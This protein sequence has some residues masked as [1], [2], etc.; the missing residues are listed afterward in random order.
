[1]RSRLAAP[2][3]AWIV[4]ALLI[5]VSATWL[6]AGQL[7]WGDDEDEP[8]AAADE[9][10][11]PATTP[12]PDWRAD[13]YAKIDQ[14]RGGLS[15]DYFKHVLGTPIFVTASD[16]G[17]YTQYLFRRRDYWVQA[18]GNPAGAVAL[19][20]VTSCDE[21]FRPVFHRFPA[22]SAEFTVTLNETM[23]AELGPPSDLHYFIG[24]TANTYFYDEYY[25]ANPGD[26]KTVWFGIND[27]CPGGEHT[28]P[29]D[30][31][32]AAVFIGREGDLVPDDPAVDEWSRPVKWCKSL[33]QRQPSSSL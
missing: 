17:Q 12:T 8:Q 10:T 2:V 26:Y 22:S 6:A 13:E 15:L 33:T 25:G 21:M 32:G 27:A 30:A 29:R 20:A 18:V 23:M 28:L 5:L 16:D 14:L 7:L 11:T 4:A 9:T 24:I 19:M 3:P 1:M 31:S